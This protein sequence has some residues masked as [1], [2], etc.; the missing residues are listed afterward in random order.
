MPTVGVRPR[1]IKSGSIDS[2]WL[3]P[4]PKQ[5]IRRRRMTRR[6][7]PKCADRRGDRFVPHLDHF[8][9]HAGQAEHAA[10][11]ARRAH[12]QI[13][14]RRRAVWIEDHAA[15]G[16]KHRLHSFC[17]GIGRLRAG[18]HRPDMREAPS[19]EQQFP[20]VAWASA[21]RVRSSAVGPSPPV[22]TT[23]SARSI[24][25]AKHVDARLQFVADSGMVVARERPFR[26]AAG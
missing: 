6:P 1:R 20:P 26:P 19:V 25:L 4:T 3:S 5:L 14:A 18:E 8:G 12:F 21:S 15:A 22:A 23:T 17:C 13:D 11:P 16:G 7:P 9:R 2:I 24:G 10:R